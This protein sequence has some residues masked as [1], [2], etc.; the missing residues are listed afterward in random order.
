MNS[1]SEEHIPE[2]SVLSDPKVK[3]EDLKHCPSWAKLLL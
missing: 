3:T 1:E 2:P